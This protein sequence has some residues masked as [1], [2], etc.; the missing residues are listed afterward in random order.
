MSTT[1]SAWS[2]ASRLAVPVFTRMVAMSALKRSDRLGASLIAVPSP[3]QVGSR[4]LGFDTGRVAE[5]GDPTVQ[6]DPCLPRYTE[7]RS[8][9]LL[10]DQ[11]RDPGKRHFGH[12]LV[13]LF[14][15]PRSQPH[16]KLVEEHQRGIRGES[17]G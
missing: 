7:H 10:N 14:D 2:G 12:D 8:G 11:D 16:G 17:A 1:L 9:E 4:Q 5:G 6:H 3:A 15:H 13:E